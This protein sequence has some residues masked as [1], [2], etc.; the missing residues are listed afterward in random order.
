MTCQLLLVSVALSMLATLLNKEIRLV[1]V[2]NG[3]QVNADNFVRYGD[4]SHAS[5]NTE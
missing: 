5:F 4:R 2:A 1:L 3:N